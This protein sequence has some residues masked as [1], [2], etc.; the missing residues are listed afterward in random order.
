MRAELVVNPNGSNHVKNTD[1]KDGQIAKRDDGL[2]YL[3]IDGVLMYIVD[4]SVYHSSCPS[5]Y[6]VELLPK[7]TEVTLTATN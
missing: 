4:G 2:V 6:Q 7:G 5:E 1:L 3:K